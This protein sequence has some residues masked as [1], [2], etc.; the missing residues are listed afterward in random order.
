[1]NKPNQR[2][3]H[4]QGSVIAS[5]NILVLRCDYRENIREKTVYI[6]KSINDHAYYSVV[7]KLKRNCCIGERLNA[8]SY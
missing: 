8:I 5:E 6:P 3:V 4:V 1:M 2:A 7:K